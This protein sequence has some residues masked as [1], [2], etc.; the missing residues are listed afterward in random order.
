MPAAEVP[1]QRRANVQTF[2]YNRDAA[3][4]DELHR[5]FWV[6]SLRRCCSRSARSAH[7]YPTADTA[8]A[9]VV[10]AADQSQRRRE[11]KRRVAAE[12]RARRVMST[13]SQ[14]TLAR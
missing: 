7:R 14:R 2:C 3:Q 5:R 11:M 12:S 6:V 9:G 4:S 13:S 8:V 10:A 1:Q